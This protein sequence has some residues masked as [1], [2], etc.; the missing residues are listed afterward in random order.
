MRKNC[1]QAF[2]NWMVGSD[3]HPARSIWTDGETLWSYDTAIATWGDYLEVIFNATRYSPT[4]TCH[5]NAIFRALGD[6]GMEIHVVT[7]IHRGAGPYSLV[8][9]EK[10]TVGA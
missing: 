5:Q 6:A 10:I 8:T 4:T 2:E 9:G 7:D 1:K 3:S